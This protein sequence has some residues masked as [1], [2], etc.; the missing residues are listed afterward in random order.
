[1]PANKKYLTRSPFQKFAKLT[2]AFIGGYMVTEALFMALMAWTDAGS[3]LFTLR[4]AGFI[5]WV[6]LMI[7]AFIGKNGWVIWGIYLLITLI[8]SVITCLGNT[9]A[10]L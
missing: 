4:Y 7:V 10:P 2:A 3:M 8:L 1:M 6:A 5:L 9:T